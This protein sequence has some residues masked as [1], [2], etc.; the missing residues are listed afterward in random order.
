MFLELGGLGL[1]NRP[2]LGV[3]INSIRDIGYSCETAVADLVDN[4]ISASAKHISIY[5]LPSLSC[6]V[7]ADD[8]CGMSEA[9]LFEAMKLGTKHDVRSDR[10]LGRFGL[11]LKT[12]SFSQCRKLVVATRKDCLFSSYCWDL[13]VLS[14]KNDW[15]MGVFSE[16]DV[17]NVIERIDKDL[18]SQFVS[19]SSGTIVVW[20]KMDRYDEEQF[21]W[22]LENVRKHLALVF[23][24]YLLYPG[25]SGQFVELSLNNS[26]IKSFDPFLSEDEK[27]N[28]AS[29]TG[30]PEE[31]T[32]SNGCKMTV[33]YHVLPPLGKLSKTEYE[34]LGTAEG[35]TKS[36]GFY[37]YRQGRLIVYGTWFGLK[38]ANDV[39]NLVR[40]E[41][42]IDNKQDNFWNIDVKKST[43]FPVS[44]IKKVLGHYVSKPIE[45]SKKVYKNIGV[46]NH[47][48]VDSY[49]IEVV[50][51]SGIVVNREN[52]K[53][54][55]LYE[56]LDFDQR[57]LFDLY[58]QGLQDCYPTKRLYSLMVLEPSDFDGNKGS[59]ELLREEIG[60]YKSRGKCKDEVR[61][62]LVADEYYSGMES[63][64]EN[65]LD[66]LYD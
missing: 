64:I 53:Y 66:E 46:K 21:T 59:E 14:E 20:Q 36:Q 45:R 57:K 11:G 37:L 7:I 34:K 31:Y 8:G 54:V 25:F 27:T 32:L 29:Q 16:L 10:D 47:E 55:D 15:E 43:A 3:F 30:K 52:R 1:Q 17:K 19:R 6:L 5:G 48:V 2:N 22:V 51:P 63:V 49:W 13:D 60:Y 42:E 61:S 26:R 62:I 56:T 24:K 40:I 41:I 33:T 35:F 65:C 12:A 9:E 44:E 50:N 28:R 23:H 38:K 58:L 4:S 39:S 18:W